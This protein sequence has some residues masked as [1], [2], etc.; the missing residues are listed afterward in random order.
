MGEAT[1]WSRHRDELLAHVAS[2][3]AADAQVLSLADLMPLVANHACP[4]HPL[5]N[6]ASCEVE[7]S[8]IG[9][10]A[11]TA[12][13]RCAVCRRAVCKQHLP[14]AFRGHMVSIGNGNHLPIPSYRYGSC[15]LCRRDQILGVWDLWVKDAQDNGRK[16]PAFAQ[17]PI[18]RTARCYR[19]GEREGRP[20]KVVDT[21][22]VGF[23]TTPDQY[24]IE[25]PMTIET[26]SR[27]TGSGRT[28]L[29][30]ESFGRIGVVDR[31]HDWYTLYG[32]GSKLE[33]GGFLGLRRLP[34]P[35]VGEDYAGVKLSSVRFAT[36]DEFERG[37]PN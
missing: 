18:F 25:I 28:G 29:F 5:V 30:D 17:E 6:A 16:V 4:Y 11:V 20:T 35:F 7:I 26:G 32:L 33:S 24:L 37:V 9:P 27:E 19:T 22:N 14:R 21:V 31:W 36:R 23:E 2:A 13:S 10:C 8:G 12:D 3:L 15:D 1:R 34:R